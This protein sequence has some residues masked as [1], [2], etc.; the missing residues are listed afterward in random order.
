MR[1]NL[2]IIRGTGIARTVFAAL[3][4]SAGLAHAQSD[5]G[6]GSEP[7][8]RGNVF[9]PTL[10]FNPASGTNINFTGV[11]SIGSNGT[12]SI[13]VAA[14]GGM[15]SGTLAT[16]NINCS[17]TGTDAGAFLVTPTNAS[18]QPGSP[19]QQ[20]SLSCSS[21]ASPRTATLVCTETAGGSPLPNRTW[22]VNC[23][24]GTP[25]T[26]PNLSYQPAPNTPVNFSAVSN[27]IGST[28]TAQI[29][30][31]PS[32]GIGTGSAATRVLSNCSI[33][34]ESVPGTFSGFQGVNFSFVGATTQVRTIALTGI[35]R[36]TA[37]TATL[38]CL[39]SLLGGRGVPISTPRSWPL[40]MAAGQPP[41]GTLSIEKTASAAQVPA[42]SEF[43][44]DI[45]VRNSS[46]GTSGGNAQEGIV[47]VDDV[48]AALTV[49]GAAGP[50][51]TCAV[52]GNNVDCRRSLLASN[53]SAGFTIDVRA[54]QTAQTVVNTAR[55]TSIQSPNQTTSSASVVIQAPP[56]PPPGNVDLRIDKRDS[57]DPVLAGAE[58]SYLIDVTNLGNTPATGVVITDPLP[59]AVQFI[60]ASGPGWA[61]SGSSTVSCTLAGTL[62]PGAISGI[63]IQVRA[64]TV[65]GVLSNTA[66][67]AAQQ[68]DVNPGNNSSTVTTEVRL[69]PPPPPDPQADLVISASAS[70][71]SALTGQPVTLRVGVQN[72]GPDP[73]VA[74]VLSGTLSDAYTTV[75]AAAGAGWACTSNGL[76]FQCTRNTIP[77][78][79]VSEI[80][81]S[82]AIRPGATSPALAS[83]SVASSTQ[84]PVPG[85]NTTQLSLPF[86]SGGA[87]LSI[88]K[89]DSVDPV[90]A[91][92]EFSYTL[93]VSNAG[94]EA[95]TGVRV[96][97]DLPASLT[98]ISASGAGYTCS[99][100]GQTVTCT[101]AASL[102]AGSAAA[103]V[104][105]VRA[106]TSGQTISNEGVVSADTS[107]PNPANNRATQ[108]T[109][110]NARTADDIAGLLGSAAVD[111]T[112][113]AALPVVAAECASPQSA[114]ADTCREIIRAADEGR[115]AEVTDALRAIA[116]EEVLAQTLI[117]REI[118][119]TQ[120]FNVDA[121][122]N[123]LRRGG[124][125]FSL[126]GLSVTVDGN[127]VP[128]SLV[129]DAFREAL[130]F[131]RDD[132]GLVSPWG[133]FVNGN[134]TSGKQD[135]NLARGNVGTDFDSTGITAGVDYRFSNRMVAGAALGYSSYDADLSG[136]SKLE[137]SSV[138]FTGYGS[139]YLSDRFYIDSRLTYGRVDFEQERRIRYRVGTSNIDALAVGKTDASQL[140]LASSMGYHL[141]YGSWSVTPN[142]TLRF[143]RSDVDAF[144]ESGAGPFNVAYSD[145]SIDSTQFAVGVQVSRALSLTQGVL[146]PQFDLSFNNESGDDAKAQARL[147][148][149]T[150]NLFRLEEQSP[151]S[152]YGTV[153]LGFVYLMGNGRQAY[154][155]YR[156]TFGFDDFDRGSL[157][158]GG[159]FEF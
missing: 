122:L 95:A 74:N 41:P 135:Q 106:P 22:P 117:L 13:N 102:P 133:F 26:P 136:D 142:A 145:Q 126:S 60:S 42:G 97:D 156:R 34:N 155:H 40:T 21:G 86:Q 16:V 61:C 28:A 68:T 66:N 5:G 52:A 82:S 11:T 150:G 71:S 17:Y 32:G 78:N 44:F 54:P 39:E 101:L 14:S 25:A 120:F 105:A 59:T 64:P 8:P 91:G 89:T 49:L 20:L 90:R 73:A 58:F 27:I 65:A 110:I 37:V 33:S 137:A 70:P 51:W 112:S 1:G 147:V 108:S 109:T 30:V 129:G 45:V 84:D 88:T 116:P 62:A 140:T 6:G 48:P 157:N 85:N 24:A 128:L 130:G 94:P 104:I 7:P 121:R 154:V 53:A 81:V 139:Y 146:L 80:V 3:L 143:I 158:L 57:V 72:R 118:G 79:D 75:S 151:D 50:G 67:V 148:Q 76:S 144:T 63:V 69:T 149:G 15:G 38:T 138:L 18:F 10:V 134:F 123:E 113:R 29:L 127:Q 47:V 152:S 93:T 36:N 124:G 98:F 99:R 131:G 55:V 19:S 43:S 87:D 107:D 153:G 111:P 125:G 141:N 9:P 96:I 132:S 83:F 31:T 119:S 46:S 4:L 103:V 92:A 100:Q 2:S 114:L 77:V 115:T 23:P 159:R 12:A 35:V 56:P